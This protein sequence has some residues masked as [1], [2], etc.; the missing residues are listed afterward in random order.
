MPKKS[1][2]KDPSPKCTAWLPPNIE[3][4]K[5]DAWTS[6][7]REVVDD[8]VIQI[9]QNQV[10][11]GIERARGL[12]NLE[13]DLIVAPVVLEIITPYNEYRYE[14]PSQEW[15]CLETFINGIR[16]RLDELFD[17]LGT[18]LV[19]QY[20]STID[21]QDIGKRAWDSSILP[22]L[23]TIRETERQSGAEAATEA[24]ISGILGLERGTRARGQLA[25]LADI[26]LS[27]WSTPTL[28]SIVREA[29]SW[30][31]G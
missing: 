16:H 5:D 13:W 12:Q 23:K 9:V 17:T 6:C 3:C 21:V 1:P 31:K 30:L 4:P 24:W 18:E 20:L 14:W 10:A 15:P 22:R 25:K 8:A 28:K 11:E 7:Y 26:R 19:K 29:R 2:K 27:R